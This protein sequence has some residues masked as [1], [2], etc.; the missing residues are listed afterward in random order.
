MKH[1]KNVEQRTF[2]QDRFEILIKK[3]KA[4]RA[5]FTELTELDEMVNRYATI[6]DTILEEMRETEPNDG[7]RENDILIIPKK[8]PVTLLTRIKSLFH[9]LFC[10]AITDHRPVLLSSF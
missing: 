3:Q 7:T 9:R 1:H 8:Q 6:R 2:L 4:G 10:L 5:S